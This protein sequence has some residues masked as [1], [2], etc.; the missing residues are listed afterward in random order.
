MGGPSAF[1]SMNK[2]ILFETSVNTHI[3]LFTMMKTAR[4]ISQKVI[5]AVI[6]PI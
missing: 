6:S 2:L 4:I 3:P 5:I 1:S